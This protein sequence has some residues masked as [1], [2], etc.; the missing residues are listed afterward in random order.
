[1][2]VWVLLVVVLV[3][4]VLGAIAWKWRHHP[5]WLRYAPRWA[6]PPGPRRGIYL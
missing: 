3:A 2:M 6:R 4:G 5:V 1:M